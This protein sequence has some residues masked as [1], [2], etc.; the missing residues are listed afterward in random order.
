MFLRCQ[1]MRWTPH[2]D[3]CL[4]K[5]DTHPE[6]HGDEMLV[7]MVKIH[8]VLDDVAQM[9]W[10]SHSSEDS[11][12]QKAPAMIYVKT[13]RQSL[14]QIKDT[15][16]ESLVDNKIALSYL[17]STDM[18][19]SDMPFWNNN[20]FT[21][22]Q[23]SRPSHLA[24]SP[25][26][27]D[28]SR[29]E[30]YYSLFANAKAVLTNYLSFLPVDIVGFSFIFI[31]HFFRS[32]QVLY[33][34]TLTEDADWDHGIV[35]ENFDLLGAIEQA[36]KRYAQVAGIYGLQTERDGAGNEVTDFFTKCANA[37]RATV[38]VWRAALGH[39]RTKGI[40][41]AGGT[42][43]GMNVGAGEGQGPEDSTS[44]ETLPDTGGNTI[45]P[46]LAIVGGSMYGAPGSTDQMTPAIAGFQEFL[47]MD[48]A[49]DDAW[50]TELVGSWDP[51]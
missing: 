25:R 51:L 9:T 21:S 1:S 31:L 11:T 14:Q 42:S 29:L 8:K 5:L 39:K 41:A 43:F 15:L 3:D 44:G 12:S 47:P 38:P 28:L 48:F 23:A 30:A 20:P 24:T 33:R 13:L 19:I 34:L 35:Q 32:T 50:W 22:P 10:R 27:P 45:G 18:I 37:L 4:R 40:H 49:M 26:S 6:W 16:P 2:M 46:D 7:F 36:A 17:Y